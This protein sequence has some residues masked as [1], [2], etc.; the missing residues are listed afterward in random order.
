MTLDLNTELAELG[1]DAARDAWVEHGRDLS[2]IPSYPEL[3]A[4]AKVGADLGLLENDRVL[5]DNERRIFVH[6]YRNE[7]QVLDAAEHKGR[8][9]R[10]R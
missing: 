5:N 8:G 9:K 10:R 4:W 3:R 2:G 7:L 6:A 1:K